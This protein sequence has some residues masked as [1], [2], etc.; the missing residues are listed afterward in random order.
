NGDND[1]VSATPQVQA[2]YALWDKAASP[3]AITYGTDRT[4]V[5]QQQS[6]LFE[7]KPANSV[8]NTRVT[9]ANAVDWTT[10]RGWY[11]D[12]VNPSGTAAG[13]RVVSMPRLE[14]GRIL[15]PTLI[16]ST[17]PCEFGG[18]SW[19]M[20]MQAVTGQRLT[21]PPLDITGDGNV[22]SS[23]TVS[24]TVGGTTVTANISGVQSREGIIDT[25]VSVSTGTGTEIMVSSGTT[26]NA[27]HFLGSTGLGR[28]RGSWRQLR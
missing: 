26:G 22:N 16:P 27:E 20:D 9:S 17:S 24:V 21:D 13:E 25:P 23:D 2:F 18:T 8:L 3:S 10:K 11:M 5:L 7:G 14:N 28:A 15:F 1:V 6:I 12:L 19:L 4:T